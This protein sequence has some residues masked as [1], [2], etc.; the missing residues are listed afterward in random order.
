MVLAP[1]I[2]SD[3]FGLKGATH[4]EINGSTSLTNVPPI[5]ELKDIKSAIYEGERALIYNRSSFSPDTAKPSFSSLENKGYVQSQL[6]LFEGNDKERSLGLPMI[7]NN[8]EEFVNSFSQNGS[9]Y[10]MIYE[11]N[12]SPISNVV[13]NIYENIY[14]ILDG[15]KSRNGENINIRL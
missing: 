3:S 13:T 2:S 7:K 4:F 5:N 10:E 6:E 15:S 1:R 14:S 9:Q 8:N 12:N 11:A